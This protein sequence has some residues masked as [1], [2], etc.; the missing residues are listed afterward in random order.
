M[1]SILAFL[2]ACGG[3]AGAKGAASPGGDRVVFGR[4][5]ELRD[6]SSVPAALPIREGGLFLPIRRRKIRV[7][8]VENGCFR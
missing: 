3:Q 5:P 7:V 4:L 1:G 8:V 6:R 2:A